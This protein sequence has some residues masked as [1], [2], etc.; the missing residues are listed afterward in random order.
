MKISV[1]GNTPKIE[2]HQEAAWFACTVTLHLIIDLF[3]HS[4]NQIPLSFKT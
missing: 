1:K 2:L 4:G 3:H